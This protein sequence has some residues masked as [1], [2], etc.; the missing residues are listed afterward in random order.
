MAESEFEEDAK[1]QFNPAPSAWRI[2]SRRVPPHWL[3]IA[4]TQRLLGLIIVVSTLL[5]YGYLVVAVVVKWI[6]DESFVR[7]VAAL[8][9]LQALA[10]ATVGF[11]FGR[12]DNTQA[13]G[14]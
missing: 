5:L 12:R 11:F 1:P 13:S 3:H 2:R 7:T 10:A 9:P 4:D 6:D 8:A 14:S